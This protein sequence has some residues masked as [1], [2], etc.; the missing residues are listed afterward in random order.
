MARS[1]TINPDPAPPAAPYEVLA[2]RRRPRGFEEVIG[3]E[4]VTRPL[5]RALESG[6]VAH[7]FV[8]SGIRGVGKTTTARILARALNCERGPTPNPCGECRPCREVAEGR[9]LDVL[10]VDAA[11]QTGIDA[12]RE[13]LE[14][15]KYQPASSRFRIYIIDEAH[16][17]SRQAVDAFLKTLEEPPPHA[18][19]ILATTAAH[20][21]SAT[22]LSRC[23]RYDF[24]A[25]ATATVA[26]ALAGLVAGE[27]REAEPE[28]LAMVAREAGGSLRDATSLLEQALAWGE[29]PL[30]ATDVRGALGLPDAELAT[31][32]L[33]S[34][35][36]GDAAGALRLLD[37]AVRGGA[38]LPR[39]TQELARQAR[40]VSLLAVGGRA[41]LEDLSEGEIT[42]AEKLA[43]EVSFEDARR[44]FRV[45]L[46]ASDEIARSSSPQMVLELALIDLALLPEIRPLDDILARLE[47]LGDGR[48]SGSPG[49]G[50]QGGGRPGSAVPRTGGTT[51]SAPASSGRGPSASARPV[52]SGAQGPRSAESLP[53]APSVAA[54]PP[55][56]DMNVAGGRRSPPGRSTGSGTAAASEMAPAKPLAAGKV[57]GGSAAGAPGEARWKRLVASLT[58]RSAA[59]FFRLSFSRLLEIDEARGDMRILVTGPEAAAALG[60]AA[61]VAEI[62]AA[63]REEFGRPFRF[64]A[65]ADENRQPGGAAQDLDRAAREDPV[66]KLSVEVLAGHIEAVLPRTRREG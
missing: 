4:H 10:E 60:E 31:A 41:L 45:L 1:K 17:L 23:Q 61:V 42:C 38:D 2:R 24:R 16:G 58:G 56:A 18:K 13:L 20:K 54:T 28:A 48:P 3:Q 57:D 32:M 30:R 12:A 66:V 7:A 9:S 59:R 33:A 63:I 43:A 26:E 50:P 49:A 8:F 62:E 19:F 55:V 65:V 29:G 44:M 11:S 25:V 37:E 35:K 39:L 51:A 47:A 36:A 6:R 5:I 34:A 14:T 52:E 22:I 46:S 15:V 21:L 40:H 27:G 64:V 53:G